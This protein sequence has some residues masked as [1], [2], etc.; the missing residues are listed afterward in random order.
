[1]RANRILF[2]LLLTSSYLFT[3]LTSHSQD[4]SRWRFLTSENG[5]AESWVSSITIAPDGAVYANHGDIL[6]FSIFD[7]F[8]IQIKKSPVST[9]RIYKDQQDQLWTVIPGEKGGIAYFN[10]ERWQISPILQKSRRDFRTRIPYLPWENELFLLF[11]D[12][13]LQ[14]NLQQDDVLIVKPLED[15]SLGRFNDIKLVDQS[16]LWIAGDNGLLKYDQTDWQEYLIPS[17]LNIG[18]LSKLSFNKNGEILM[19]GKDKNTGKVD[20]IRFNNDK[21]E[22]LKVDI[23]GLFGVSSGNDDDIWYLSHTPEYYKIHHSSDGILQ[24]LGEHKILSSR[25]TDYAAD[26]EGKFWLTTTAGLA[27]YCP[28]PWKPLS[29]WPENKPANLLYEDEQQR[30]WIRTTDSI[31]IYDKGE[32]TCIPFGDLTNQYSHLSGDIIK[33]NETTYYVSNHQGKLIQFNPLTNSLTLSSLPTKRFI[34]EYYKSKNGTIYYLTYDEAT[35]KHQLASLTSDGV[36]TEHDNTID[37]NN[38]GNFTC[39]LDTRKYGLLI[40]GNKRI[41]A[42][43]NDEDVQKLVSSY[44]GRGAFSLL[45]FDDGRI[46]FGERDCI[47]EY[48]GL[49]WKYIRKTGLET[50][51][52]MIQASDGS[53]WIGSG[54]GLHH[55]WKGSWIKNDKFDG[56]PDTSISNVFQDSLNTLWVAT[57]LG[58]Y[59]FDGDVDQQ[60]P[61]TF[62]LPN[63]NPQEILVNTD[64]FISFS[65]QDKW[66]FTLADHLKYAFRFD[67]QS[68]GEYLSETKASTAHLLPGKHTIQVKSIDRCMNIDPTPALFSFTI[69]NPWYKETKALVMFVIGSILLGIS[70]IY[71][72]HRHI[73]LHHLVN[74]RTLELSN[75]NTELKDEIAIRQEIEDKL[76]RLRNYLSNIIDSMPSL[77]I[78]VDVHGKVTQWNKIAEQT[79]GITSA[80]AQGKTLS[81]VFPHMASEMEK[82]AESIRSRETKREQKKFHLSKKGARYED[83]TIYPLIANGV[84]GA[85]IRI[86]DVTDK[87]RMEEMM[88]Q[89]EKML[90]VGGLAAGMAHE[91]NNPLAGMMQTAE[92]MRNRLTNI[93][94]PANHRAAGEVGTSM[95]TI[96][97]FMEKRDVPDMLDRINE[98]GKRAAVIVANMLSF[99][100]KSGS[101]FSIHNLAELLDNTVD[102]AGSDYNLKK[103]FDFRQI[104]IVREYEDDLPFAPCESSKI[105]QVFLNILRNGAEAMHEKMEKD[106]G[107][108]PRFILRLKHE[109]ETA[110]IRIE[111]EDNGSGM[112]EAT[113][114]R[115]FE[116][117]FTTKP[118]DQGAGLGLSVS[119]FI[120]TENHGGEMSVESTLGQGTQFV[121]RLP[122]KLK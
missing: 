12:T 34:N 50:V 87:V 13:L 76:R 14:T 48:D 57:S 91:I 33:I 16:T 64:S 15:T 29:Q 27:Y 22:R 63:S 116:P 47:L 43:R 39:M 18:Q 105:Q 53:I 5:L 49:E 118:P 23:N 85:V 52:S 46:W 90:S 42:I 77:L 31:N 112:D 58:I 110:M 3:S 111:I 83:V 70:S 8:S 54:N 20:A 19:I 38:T 95:E 37:F 117:F 24:L 86:D 72:I 96:R 84:E 75:T 121:I 62:I 92:V 40:A 26:P 71:A 44:P 41:T 6:E 67:Q 25:I 60:T 101:S 114:K 81:D 10:Q 82:I 56:L 80:A 74:Q 35:Q 61:D 89:S 107:K 11:P 113:R 103:K 93:E 106:I 59:Y 17:S 79:T 122:N 9:E 88:I 97:A 78:G 36:F 120:I 104:E 73:M 7:G 1:M 2:G 100:R 98:S 66:N 65:G 28:P 55:Y 32:I 102:L 119:Y 68:W 4:F 51:R 108:K 30:L 109:R 115:V 21:W 99:A 94:L 69:K 45:E